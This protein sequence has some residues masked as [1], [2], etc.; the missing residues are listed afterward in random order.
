MIP[1]FHA[2][3]VFAIASDDM[4]FNALKRSRE[5]EREKEEKNM[6]KMFKSQPLKNQFEWNNGIL[7]N[8]ILT[9]ISLKRVFF[10]TPNTKNQV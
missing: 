3:L 8:S 7:F 6:L 2:Y 10:T 1:S 9:I 4:A 5:R